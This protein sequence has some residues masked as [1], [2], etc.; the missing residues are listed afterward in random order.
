MELDYQYGIIGAG[1]GGIVA[2]LRL[3][4]SNRNSFVIF[5]KA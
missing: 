1:F 5:E 3:K 4:E 2:A